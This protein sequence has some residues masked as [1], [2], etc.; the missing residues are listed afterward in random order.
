MKNL[1]KVMIVT[2]PESGF[3]KGQ[4][5]WVFNLVL[6]HKVPQDHSVRRQQMNNV[7]IHFTYYDLK[8][9]THYICGFKC[10]V[11][12]SSMVD[13][14]KRSRNGDNKVI[15]GTVTR[16]IDYTDIN[17]TILFNFLWYYCQQ[18]GLTVLLVLMLIYIL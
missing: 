4:G 8:W 5:T 9:V 15:T 12:V 16:S 3:F 11:L 17:D 6:C 14:L 1:D 18:S 13:G 7:V 2:N 10:L